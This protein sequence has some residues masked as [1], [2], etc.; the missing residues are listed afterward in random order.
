MNAEVR[1]VR[2]EGTAEDWA[3]VQ[4][5]VKVFSVEDEDEVEDQSRS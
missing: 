5:W 3:E 1:Q 4:R 2:G